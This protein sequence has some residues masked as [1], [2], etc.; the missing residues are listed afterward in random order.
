MF[1]SEIEW[2]LTNGPRS[3]SCDRVIRYPGLGVCSV[4][5]VGDFLECPN[6]KI[7][8]LSPGSN[9]IFWLNHRT[10]ETR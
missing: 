4:G 7:A 9:L 1:P 6:L 5:H 8:Q 3:V 10:A 2:D